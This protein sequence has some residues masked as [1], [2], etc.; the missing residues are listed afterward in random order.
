MRHAVKNFQKIPAKKLELAKVADE[1]K[2]GLKRQKLEK[3]LPDYIEKM[4]KDAN[5][6]ILDAKIKAA[7]EMLKAANKPAAV[8]EKKSDE[9]KAEPKK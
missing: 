3:L 4:E 2:E 7:D 6:E 8:P 5:V 1:L 9:K